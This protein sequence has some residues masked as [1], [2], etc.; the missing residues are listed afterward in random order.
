LPDPGHDT[1]FPRSLTVEFAENN[2]GTLR[3]RNV[4]DRR[5]ATETFPRTKTM[6]TQF[7]T[8]TRHT[9][10]NARHEGFGGFPNPLF[11][12]PAMIKDR[13]DRTRTVQRTNTQQS[14]PR[15][16]S[17][18]GKPTL[19]RTGTIASGVFGDPQPVNY[20]SFDAVVGR[21]SHFKSLT[22]AQEEELGGVE[23][24]V[25]PSERV[26]GKL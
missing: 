1:A 2:D 15:N 11:A 22:A 18:N 3:R 9:S 12:I 10:S 21:N 13:L 17:M 16:L 7:S 20:I 24:R 6:A 8:T 19:Q 23:Y 26:V 4:Q 14:M 25:R 5:H